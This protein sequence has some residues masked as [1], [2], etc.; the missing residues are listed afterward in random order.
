MSCLHD[1]DAGRNLTAS[2]CYK[3]HCVA[4]LIS[5]RGTPCSRA[6]SEQG[7]QGMDRMASRI[8][9]A[10]TSL[11]RMERPMTRGWGGR[12][13]LRPRTMN[14]PVGRYSPLGAVFDTCAGALVV[15]CRIRTLQL[16]PTYTMMGST[17][18]HRQVQVCWA[19]QDANQSREDST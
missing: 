7:R 15:D 12:N 2:S 16:V 4:I 18:K 5:I 8:N 13:F 17:C 6:P 14:D 19:T 10:R 3:L 1:K 9:G 11:K